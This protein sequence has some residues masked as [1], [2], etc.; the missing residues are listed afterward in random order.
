MVNM[1]KTEEKIFFSF[2]VDKLNV[3]LPIEYIT[4]ALPLAELKFLPNLPQSVIGLLNYQGDIYPVF[5]LRKLYRD[6]DL[7]LSINDHIIIGEKEGFKFG[8]LATRI[9]G[10]ISKPLEANE[11]KAAPKDKNLLSNKY[12]QIEDE[13]I[14]LSDPAEFLLE[15]EKSQL[16]DIL[17]QH[18][19]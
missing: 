17:Q 13:L 4:K 19:S 14:C 5:D 11:Q 6:E 18:N 12:V 16:S 7:S 3:A 10:N 8:V 1:I 15:D 2:F 9:V